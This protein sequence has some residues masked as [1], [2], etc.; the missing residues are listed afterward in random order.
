MEKEIYNTIEEEI[1]FYPLRKKIKWDE[2]MPAYSLNQDAY[3]VS[4]SEVIDYC[5]ALN[6]EPEELYLVS[7]LPVYLKKVTRDFW[8]DQLDEDEPLP[9]A[10]DK[11]L[12]VLNMAVD[13][14]DPVAYRPA[15][16]AIIIPESLKQ[17]AINE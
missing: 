12:K 3:F 13:M 1:S 7:C 15:S 8:K 11:A 5:S 14:L 2:I 16:E 10:V 9:S 4:W 17:G 6:L